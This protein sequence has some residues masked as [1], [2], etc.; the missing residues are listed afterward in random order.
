MYIYIYKVTL[1][2]FL[3]RQPP[4]IDQQ[5]WVQWIQIVFEIYK[6]LLLNLPSAMNLSGAMEHFKRAKLC[7]PGRHL[8]LF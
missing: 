5:T 4:S 8:K 1:G 7:P 2:T 3:R 6:I